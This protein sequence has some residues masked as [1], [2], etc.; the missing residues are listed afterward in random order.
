MAGPLTNALNSIDFQS[1]INSLRNSGWLQYF[2]PFLLVY[3]ITYVVL[4][5][6]KLFE[7]KEKKPVRVIISLVFAITSIAFDVTQGHTL[8]DLLYNLFPGVSALSVAILGL[9][10]IMAMFDVDPMEFT[11]DKD[12]DKYIKITLGVIGVIWLIYYFGLG[13]GYWN[14]V[15]WQDNFVIRLLKD[16]TLWILVVMYFTFKWIS[17]DET[18]NKSK[19]NKEDKE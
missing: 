13:L 5:K 17:S 11:G 4:D 14:N 18:E 6:I 8:G 16:P 10:I 9:Y 7:G 15:N 1:I 12:I 3:A 2:F 19:K